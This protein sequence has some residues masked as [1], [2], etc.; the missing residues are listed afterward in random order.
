M[1]DKLAEHAAATPFV[2]IPP[3]QGFAARINHNVE[4]PDVL[5][6]S[7]ELDR[8]TLRTFRGALAYLQPLDGQQSDW[9]AGCAQR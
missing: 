5:V 2:C 1:N 3:S 6:S 9:N 4:A 8:Q 7:T